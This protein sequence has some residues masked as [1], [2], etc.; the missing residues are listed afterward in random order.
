MTKQEKIIE[1]YGDYWEIL[2][3]YISVNGWISTKNLYDLKFNPNNFSPLDVDD[4]EYIANYRPKS[5]QGIENN[6]GWIKIE[7]ESD[8]PNE[9]Y[10]YWVKRDGLD[11]PMYLNHEFF[12]KE[13]KEYWLKN[14]TH[15]QKAIK[16]LSPIY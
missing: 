10:I 16:P 7:S 9:S 2:K 6:N 3:D 12:N 15:Y 14:Y 8:L 11:Y 13:G 5:L 1:A 4:I